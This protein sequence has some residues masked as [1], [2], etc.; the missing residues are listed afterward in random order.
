MYKYDIS[1]IIVNYN[2]KDFL[3]QCLKSIDESHQ[4]L[5]IEIIVVDNHS[6]DHSV[7][8]LEPMFPRVH[9][10]KLNENLGFAKANNI[11]IR[12]ATGKYILILNPDTL[13][14]EDTLKIMFEYMENNKEVGISGCKVLNSDGTF[15]LACRRGFPTPWASFCKLFGLQS[16]FPK[17]RLFSKYN[18]TFRSIDETYYID[19]VIGA[20]MFCRAEI[21]DKV[22]LFD[23]DYFM[24]G[25]DIDLCYRT[26]SLGYE[27]AYVHKTSII[28]YKGESTKRSSINGLKHFYEA[29]EIFS[30][31]HF[32]K[33][34][35]FLKFIKLGILLRSIIARFLKY[36]KEIFLV[37]FDVLTINLTFIIGTKIRFGGYFN[38]PDYAYP[39]VFIVLTLVLLFSMIS[40]G[41]YF[42]NK[43]II[44]RSITA[45]MITFFILSSLTYFF[46]EYAFSRGVL[47][48]TIGLSVLSTS[49]IRLLILIYEKLIGTRADRK[50]IFIGT[51]TDKNYSI[52]EKMLESGNLNIN[53]VG[54][55][56][57]TDDY[58][59][60][61][62]YKILGNIDY[63]QKI[64][65]N[66]QVN[67][68]I[69]TDKN[70][71]Y[72][73][74]I[75][76]ILKGSHK[77]VR[78]HLVNEYEELQ[79]SDM[80]NEITGNLPYTPEYNILKFRTKLYKRLIDMAIPIFLLTLGLPLLY[81]LSLKEDK[82]LKELWEIIIG[83]KTIIGIY[84][85]N[86]DS[87]SQLKSGLTGLVHLIGANKLTK[88]Q[89]D[90]LNNYYLQ[91]V[92][93]SLDFDIMLKYIFR[94]KIGN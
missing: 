39:L 44:R 33:S 93:I 94:K 7:K 16:L 45:L 89:I 61:L 34:S 19:A 78:F 43:Y 36:K 9:F 46:K 68:V 64:I 32:S 37:F 54:W 47:L 90:D 30:K 31:K 29:M 73:D 14:F 22:G 18:Q 11:G 67:D 65:E 27:I 42:E 56:S 38:L 72:Q 50:I 86:G 55:V 92:N 17:W 70:I 15:Q 23:E 48:M 60:Q 3:L 83:K 91:N 84:N 41:A 49:L 77:K 40:T 75:N 62:G 24:Y 66:Y 6:T 10:I 63:L 53:V 58:D 52:I 13:L 20:F 12:Q 26:K 85:Y 74:I 59:D 57:T 76:W 81:L 51:N 69:I 28:H 82:I 87:E 5:K 79:I 1:I 80:I 88:N 4:Y 25:E 71:K 35:L 2:V 8:L 21:F